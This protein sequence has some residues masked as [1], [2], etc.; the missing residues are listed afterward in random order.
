M[1][2][3]LV[4]SDNEYLITQFKRI[5]QD[6][7]YGA[8]SFNFRYSFSNHSFASKF[9]DSD[10]LT[11][12]N[13][14]K[15]CQY[16]L[17]NYELVISLHCKQLFP[18]EL[19]GAVKCINIH[20]GLNPYNRGW[21]PQVFSIINNLPYG[22][23]IHEIDQY[24]DNGPII[25]QKE[26]KIESYD[27]SLTLYNKVLLVEVELLKDNLYSI[28]NN[29]Y[30]SKKPFKE[31]NLNLK[32]DFYQLCELNLSHQGSLKEHINLL[33]ALTHGEH[34]NGYFYDEY[35]NKVYIKLNLYKETTTE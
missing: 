3:I 8:Y 34:Q 27:T 14:K 19:V 30:V 15:D 29:N 16:I 12:I 18:A 6:E 35:N 10:W 5:I 32:K 11:S 28:I 26:I 9:K 23:T 22:A 17:S 4:I 25:V 24:L 2:N 13:V 1:K 20:P 31:G 33:R 21:F 7:I